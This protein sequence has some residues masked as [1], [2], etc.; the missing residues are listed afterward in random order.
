[1]KYRVLTLIFISFTGTKIFS[2]WIHEHSF[3]Q[4][5]IFYLDV[6]DTSYVWAIGE[7]GETPV[8]FRKLGNF[9]YPEDLTDLPHG[10]QLYTCVAGIDSDTGFVGTKTGKI[11]K[12]TNGGFNWFQILDAGNRN[13]V[14]IKFSKIHRSTGYIFCSNIY[15]PSSYVIYKTTNYGYTWQ[16]FSQYIGHYLSAN[17]PCVWITDSAHVWCT[18]GCF[19]YSTCTFQKV[20]YTTNGGL[21]WLTSG[22][23]DN[24]RFGSNTVAFDISNQIGLIIT[25]AFGNDN[26]WKTTNGGQNWFYLRSFPTRINPSIVNMLGSSVWYFGS[27]SINP[28]RAR[29]FKSSNNGIV[30][31]EMTMDD[32]TYSDFWDIDGVVF[33]NKIH[34]WAIVYG[35]KNLNQP[36]KILRLID[37]LTII[38]VNGQFEQLPDEFR[39][40]QNYPNPFNP[41]TKIKFEIPSKGL[42]KNINVRLLVYDI[43]GREVAVLLNQELQP[44][45][46]DIEWDSSDCASGMYFYRIETPYFTDSKKMVVLR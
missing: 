10:S 7:R 40:Y 6:I 39:L 28:I 20:L 44:G 5:W 35:G 27:M 36:C 8:I 29:I 12:T 17:E 43:T 3:Y 37:T 11:Y 16:M 23:N 34:A 22:F 42:Y 25:Y 32:S 45:V 19:D 46:Y 26:L 38:G 41:R 4:A 13:V 1:M 21:T 14:G 9:W 30:W 31:T 2:Q 18:L 15:Q 33:D 24:G